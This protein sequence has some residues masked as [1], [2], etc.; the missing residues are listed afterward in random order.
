MRDCIGRLWQLG[1]VQLDY[2]LPERFGLEYIGADNQAHRPVMIH[3]APFGSMERFFGI[4]IEHFAGAFPLWLAPEQVRILSISEKF[5]EYARTVEKAFLEKG[6]RATV[7]ARPEKINY[8]V[9][10]A[11]LEKV[12]YMLVVGEKEQAA[13][14]VSVRDRV[15]GDLGAKPVAEVLELLAVEVKD[16]RIRQVSTASAGLAD[17]GAKFAT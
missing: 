7:D 9:R 15:D 6:F 14:T 11:Q 17:S 12:P 3:R 10:E 4:L 5:L 16:R 13:G 8:K 2:N 1:T